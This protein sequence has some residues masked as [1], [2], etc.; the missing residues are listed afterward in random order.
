ML[1]ERNLFKEINQYINSKEAVIITGMRRT[2]KTSLLKFIYD[3]ITSQNKI[4]LDLENPLNQKYFEQA[5]YDGIASSLGYLGLDFTQMAY[6]FLDEIHLVKT[7]PQIVKYLIDHY[8]I[9]FF[10]TGSASFYM[11]NLFTESLVGRKYIFE[12]F[13]L[14][15]KEFLKFKKSKLHLAVKNSEITKPIFD[16]FSSLYD[17]YLYFGGFPEVVLKERH[18]EKKRSLEDIFTSYFQLE[19]LRL[20]DFRKNNIIRDLILLLM[21]RTGSKL[22]INKMASELGISRITLGEYISFLES[23]Y[24]I[25]TIKPFSNNKD[26]EIRKMPKVYICDCGL[27]NHFAKISEGSLFE[28]NIFQNLRPTGEVNYYQRKNGAEIDFILNTKTAYEVK[29][30]PTPSDI[31]KLKKISNEIGIND[32]KII[33]RHFCLNTDEMENIEYGFLI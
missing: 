24:F 12:L 6:I 1:I 11:K 10:L 27:I 17:E 25:K 18:E 7:I 16:T 3:K 15:F 8:N 19:V 29:T 4:F 22:D 31:K 23:T 28:N 33:S 9:K 26:M 5:N 20:G 2:G 30:N 13:P 21:Q 32:Y 14:N